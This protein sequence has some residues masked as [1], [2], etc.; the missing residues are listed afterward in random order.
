[1]DPLEYEVAHI[2]KGLPIHPDATSQVSR[3]AG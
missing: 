1:V 3:Y 2:D